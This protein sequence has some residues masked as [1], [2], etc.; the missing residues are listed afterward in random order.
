MNNL[1][2]LLALSLAATTAFGTAAS[3]TFTDSADVTN[4]NAVEVLSTLGIIK[5]IEASDGTFSFDPQGNVTRAQMCIMIFILENGG[6]SNHTGFKDFSTGLTD[7]SGHWAEGAIKYCEI[8]GYVSGFGDGTFR[9]EDSVTTVQA[10]KMLVNGIGYKSSLAGIGGSNWDQTTIVY[11]LNHGLTAGLDSYTS[12]ATREDAA[13]FLYNALY[14]NVVTWSEDAL[15][16]YTNYNLTYGE[17]K[18]GLDSFKAEVTGST[19]E[20]GLKLSPLGTT[21]ISSL[22]ELDLTLVENDYTSF[23]GQEVEVFTGVINGETFEYGMRTLSTT[24]VVNAQVSDLTLSDTDKYTV[25][26]DGVTVEVSYSDYA[27]IKSAYANTNVYAVLNE[28]DTTATVTLTPVDVAEVTYV[29]TNAITAGN[30]S[31]KFEDDNIYSDVAVGDFVQIIADKFYENNLIEEVVTQEGLVTV[32]T[33]ATTQYTVGGVKYT[34]D[35]SVSAL[36]VGSTYEF[37]AVG[38]VIYSAELV[39]G[40]S[41]VASIALLANVDD[42]DTTYKIFANEKSYVGVSLILEDG[43]QLDVKVDEYTN[44]SGTLYCFDADNKTVGAQTTG[45][46]INS[47]IT[48]DAHLVSY[49]VGT[50]GYASVTALAVTAADEDY[51]YALDAGTVDYRGDNYVTG[52]EKY[53]ITNDTVIY[54]SYSDDSSEF[55][56]LTSEEYLALNSTVG[57]V[58]V[59]E[60]TYSLNKSTNHYN[61]E[62]L[63]VE[64]DSAE[65]DEAADKD[66]DAFL[67][68]TSDFEK[69]I[70]TSETAY[71]YYE[72]WDGEETVRIKFTSDQSL[73]IGDIVEV[74]Y[75]EDGIYET[76]TT[77][78]NFYTASV[79]SYTEDVKVFT[80]GGMYSNEPDAQYVVADDA[81]VFYVDEDNTPLSGVNIA[82]SDKKVWE[83]ASKTQYALDFQYKLNSDNEIE[84]IVY[85]VGVTID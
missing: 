9:P 69:E 62:V 29:G 43:S 17:D 55:A 14:A 44:A 36:T 19:F 18:M 65:G 58:L 59:Q 56:L 25:S 49:S 80:L 64:L 70:I 83:T 1:K 38:S 41:E 51:A 67:L 32:F 47:A 40:E 82:L 37:A 12:N 15:Q 28:G 76:V 20:D 42:E 35:N 61:V 74:K 22:T 85:V 52:T 57:D 39:E 54:V 77:V 23:I 68:I 16:Y 73:T 78:S 27:D 79:I 6:S 26:Y 45:I 5:G 8:K 81:I 24:K 3:A 7:I 33:N 84:Y 31:Y 11:A 66:S 2:K 21:P 75:D 63:Y 71:F 50:D 4:T 34:L 53:F 13:Q 48:D 10:L 72:A 60:Y 46:Q 30:V